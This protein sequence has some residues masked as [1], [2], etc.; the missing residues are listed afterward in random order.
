[1]AMPAS[2]T[3]EPEPHLLTGTHIHDPP[4]GGSYDTSY[5][6]LSHSKMVGDKGH[7]HAILIFCLSCDQRDYN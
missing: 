4:R 7:S 3:A 6:S 1:M 2:H 5:L